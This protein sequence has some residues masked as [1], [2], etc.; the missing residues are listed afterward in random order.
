MNLDFTW[1][2]YGDAYRVFDG[3]GGV[4]VSGW[5]ET[6]L[7]REVERLTRERDEARRVFSE[8]ATER[9]AYSTLANEGRRLLL[10]AKR[11]RDEARAQAE[12]FRTALDL[13][14]K[15][16]PGASYHEL[17]ERARAALAALPAPEEA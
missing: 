9:L 15:R 16:P 7:I 2:S 10:Q 13:F 11:E 5:Y 17:V 12:G 3:S 6:R 4:H 1:E 8:C 14:L